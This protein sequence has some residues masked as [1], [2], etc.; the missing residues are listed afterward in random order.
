MKSVD[1][2]TA[3]HWLD[4]QEAIMVD[5]REPGEYHTV[6]IEGTVLIPLGSLT[7]E[8]LPDLK[9]KKLIIHCHLGKRGS[10][11]C[12]KLLS[13]WPELEVYNLEG[14]LDAWQRAGLKVIS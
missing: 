12:H 5:V 14:G 13:E 9:G 4:E 10:M 6:H 8:A 3:K 7:K 11:A 2:K 1:P